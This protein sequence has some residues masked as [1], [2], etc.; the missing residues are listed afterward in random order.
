VEM[1]NCL[2]EESSSAVTLADHYRSLPSHDPSNLCLWLSRL[3]ERL[4]VERLTVGW[5]DVALAVGVVHV[6]GIAFRSGLIGIV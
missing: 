6:D 2:L 5:V 3:I 1:S 4:L